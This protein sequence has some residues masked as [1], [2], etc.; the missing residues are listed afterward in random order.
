ML[1]SDIERK[2]KR[3][4]YGFVGNRIRFSDNLGTITFHSV[5]LNV[6]ISK[7]IYGSL[8]AAKPPELSGSDQRGRIRKREHLRWM[9]VETVQ[10]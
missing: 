7:N 3:N 8:L 5:S 1:K 4:Y 6:A 2:C 9:S 10:R